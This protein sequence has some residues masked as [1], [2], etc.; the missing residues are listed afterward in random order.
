MG[1]DRSSSFSSLA[2]S[3]CAS[4]NNSFS[5][6]TT[7]SPTSSG[8]PMNSPSP[9]IS[10]YASPMDSPM[11]STATLQKMS[12][13]PSTQQQ[14]QQ[15][16]KANNN[17]FVHKLF[18]MVIDP[19]Y[20][21]LISWNYTNAS[22]I[23]CNIVEFSRDVLPKHF[24]HNNFS[25]FVR[26]LNMYGF[27]KVNKSPR[28]HRTLAENQIW[29]FSHP[30]FMRDRHDL[31]DEI[32]R[33]ALETDNSRRDSSDVGSHLSMM[34]M[35]QSDIVQQ[36]G[37]LQ[38]NFDQVVQELAET[39][40]RQTAQQELMK[41]MMEFLSQRQGAQF[42]IPSDFDMNKPSAAPS[43]TTAPDQP[44]SILITSPDVGNSTSMDNYYLPLQD[45]QQPHHHQPSSSPFMQA[46]ILSSQNPHH[47]H[48]HH[49]HHQQQQQQ[50]PSQHFHPS[51]NT[52]PTLR[53]TTPLTVQT[54]NL[55]SPV[56]MTFL[57]DGRS[58]ISPSYSA[59]HT[60]LSS[61]PPP[62][63]THP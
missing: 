44:P 23:V 35:T 3:T 43:S 50:Q 8:S 58:P 2:A 9:T 24:K 31:L 13:E 41:T 28:G 53:R 12:L 55:S 36:L 42:Q 52:K 39:K 51:N 56:D 46:P 32:K 5:H 40:Q 7:D 57:G 47:H 26:Q 63:A 60:P 6:I 62:F 30:K 14:Q 54:Q 48:H 19:H 22:F 16:T 33:K 11:D 61:T 21:H 34:Q 45:Q 25:S 59:Y 1:H 37:R 10:P 49:H 20:Q 4:V 27:H 29:E 38:E 18:N 17:T 15:T